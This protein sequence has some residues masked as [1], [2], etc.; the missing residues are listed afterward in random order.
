MSSALQPRY[1][2]WECMGASLYGFHVAHCLCA[3]ILPGCAS[4]FMQH[5][6]LA[7]WKSKPGILGSSI[8]AGRLPVLKPPVIIVST[9]N[10]LNKV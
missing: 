4:V 6:A 8:R 1:I 3:V 2:K 5:C 9:H 10:S 7:L